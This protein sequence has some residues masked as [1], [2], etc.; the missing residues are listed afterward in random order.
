VTVATGIFLQVFFPPKNATIVMILRYKPK[1]SSL[2]ITPYAA[3]DFLIR[4]LS[5][6]NICVFLWLMLCL[7]ANHANAISSIQISVGEVEAPAGNL[8]N[9]HFQVDLKG[10]APALKLHAEVKPSNERE[11]TKFNLACGTFLS[12]HIGELDCFNGQFVAKKINIPLTA[13]FKSM[14]DD[15]SFNVDFLDAHFSDETGV[16]AGEKLTGKMILAAN[17]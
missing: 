2:H 7:F 6:L 9:A 10:E 11:F 1:N 12:D 8:K 17:K 16:H 15:F 14:P 4:A 3:S 13:H 5:H